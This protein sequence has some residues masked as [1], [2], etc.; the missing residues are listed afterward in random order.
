M[1]ISFFFFF[2]PNIAHIWRCNE[3]DWQPIFS[4]LYVMMYIQVKQTILKKN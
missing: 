1:T 3:M 4:F 2:T